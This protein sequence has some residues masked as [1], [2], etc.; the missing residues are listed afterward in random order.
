MDTLGRR[1]SVYTYWPAYFMRDERGRQALI[2]AGAD[3]VDSPDGA[4]WALVGFY[5]D[6]PKFVG[7]ARNIL[8]V[9]DEPRYAIGAPQYRVYR[10]TPV[11]VFELSLGHFA[12][13]WE[14]YIDHEPMPM[15]D[16]AT[17]RHG[18]VF[19]ASN[20]PELV[21]TVPIDMIGIRS[22]LAEY[23]AR[24]EQLHLYGKNWGELGARGESRQGDGE[25][26]WGELKLEILANYR[27]NIALENSFI[28][29]YISE[30][31]WQA[32]EGGCLPVYLGSPWMDRLVDP[33]LY[34][35]LRNLDTPEA[36]FDAIARLDETD[37][38]ARVLA[39]QARVTELRAQARPG[40]WDRW[41]RETAERLIDLDAQQQFTRD[42]WGAVNTQQWPDWETFPETAKSTTASAPTAEP[43]LWRRTASRI[44]RRVGR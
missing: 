13:F 35:D 1:P 31:F 11:H 37:R 25:K 32:V 39:L 3:V 19:V 36:V 14:A 18:T 5:K 22:A 41:R 38:V 28:P 34:L 43:A 24:T 12:D 44:A 7:K 30:K 16:P 21:G 29:G 27:V 20:Q 26:S 6:V 4:D 2:D 17:E 10:D 33:A 8:V 40:M 9:T 42:A 15:R 23:G